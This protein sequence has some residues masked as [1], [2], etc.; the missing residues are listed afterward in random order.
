MVVEPRGEVLERVEDDV[1]ARVDQLVAGAA[2]GE[3]RDAHDAGGQRPL[4]VVHVVADVDRGALVPQHVGLADP[5]HL[6]GHQVDVEREVVD[7]A[8]GVGGE[9]AGHQQRAAAVAAYGGERL[10]RA[11]ERGDGE[12]G[13]V[14][15]QLAE[16]GDGRRDGLGRQVRGQHVVER[17]AQARGQV[18]DGQVDPELVGEHGQGGGE[19][20]HGVDEGHVEVEPHHE[21]GSGIRGRRRHARQRT[22]R[23]AAGRTTPALIRPGP[24]DTMGRSRDHGHSCPSTPSRIRKP[25][26][27][28]HRRTR[29]PRAGLRRAS[30]VAVLATVAAGLSAASISA[31]AV[32]D[33]EG[34][35]ALR[36]VTLTGP[37]TSAGE[38]GAAGLLARQDAVL[39]RVGSPATT[40]RWT[41]ALNGFAAE[42]TPEQVAAIE[43]DPEVESV[44]ANEVRAMTGRRGTALASGQVGQPRATGG[45]GVVIGVVDSGLAPESPLFA[46]VPGLG[47]APE[48]FSG[49]CQEGEDWPASTCNRKVVAS[50]WWVAGFGEDRIRSSEHLSPRDAVGH[51][52]QVASVAA[53]NAGVS[54]R[55]QG[56]TVGQFGGIAPQARIAAY[57]ACW[58]APDPGDDGCATAD[59]V[60]AIDRATADGVDVLNLAVAGPA[61]H[62][63]RRARPARRRGGRHRR[64]GR[65]RQR[66]AR[67]VRRARQPVGHDGRRLARAAPGRAA[68]PSPAARR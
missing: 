15:V 43:A 67:A 24:P 20:R 66:R 57:K 42:L 34:V 45:A 55:M 39:A 40:Y 58:G 19:A 51:G 9:L 30:V 65:R 3:H 50:G 59:L 61:R 56:R 14:G 44:E 1:G 18:P 64:R 25:A 6:A 28:H 37:G 62:R 46:G 10:V 21:P 63:H 33:G 38:A 68:S 41:T 11:G 60:S 8:P 27:P 4:D 48:D 5:P 16:A 2:A 29:T 23:G 7:V 26:V 52:T 32:A 54:V 12:D 17:G 36:L 22:A 31:P 47:R 13:V 53:G 49:T 35:P